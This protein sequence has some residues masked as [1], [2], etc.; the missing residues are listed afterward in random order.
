M[1]RKKSGFAVFMLLAA[2]FS[3]LF[4]CGQQA[5]ADYS[6]Q[7]Y[8]VTVKADALKTESAVNDC[9]G[10][11]TEEEIRSFEEKMR[12]MR[13]EY[14]CNAIAFIIDDE[15]WDTSELSAPEEVS[16]RYLKLDDHKSTVVL[17]LN[18]CRENRSLYVLGYGS[19]EWKINDSEADDLAR[20]LQDYVKRQQGKEKTIP[21]V[22]SHEA[23]EKFAQQQQS[24]ESGADD[25]T[26][27]VE[28]MNKFISR[29]DE[30]MRRPYFFL[31]WWFHLGLGIVVG[32]IVV[33]TLLRNVGGKMTVTGT[34]YMNKTFSQVIGRRDIYTHT[35]TVRTRKSSSS[36]GGG[37]SGGGGHSHSSG[38][39]RF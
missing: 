18:V 15:N 39:G 22:L 11:Y 8:G 34:T 1:M 28:M 6:L 33:L 26:L 30:E 9:A 25:N 3:G 31:T 16:E 21:K 38:G 4:L 23:Y 7:K 12:Q 2:L 35:T 37:R 10:L 24:G 32:L 19:A 17:W 20:T 14:D 5:Y 27:Y 36:G 13:E 29:V